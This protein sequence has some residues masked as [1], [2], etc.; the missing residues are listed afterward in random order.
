MMAA[1]IS[2][3]RKP[4]KTTTRK[5]ASTVH[6]GS[7][8]PAVRRAR[9]AVP[10]ATMLDVSAARTALFTWL[11]ARRSGGQLVI[12]FDDA[13]TNEG[14]VL[15]DLHWLGL[16]WDEPP[17]HRA[18]REALY[19]THLDR[20]IAAKGVIERD[21]VLAFPLAPGTTTVPDA[22]KGDVAFDHRAL[23]EVVVAS[24]AG[25]PSHAF[26]SAV[27]DATM[28]IDLVVEDDDQLEA[29]AR[30]TLL[31]QALGFAPPR[32]AHVGPLVDADHHRLSKRDEAPTIDG[33]RR[34]G[35]Q[36]SA[37]VQHLALLG[38]S[39]PDGGES[40]TI[41][42]LVRS[43][44]LERVGGAPSVF[45]L[46]RLRAFNGRAL[47]A[48]SRPAYHDLLAERMQRARL[49]E[50]PIP[51]A[52]HRWIET[53]LDA[54]GDEVHTLGEAIDIIAALREESV[55]VPALEL[56]RLRNR[57][58]LFF[59]DSVSQY[60]DAQP[61]LR[62]LPLEHDLPA[63]ADEFG[64]ARQDAFPAVRM[65]LSGTHDGPPLRLLFPLLGHDR[66]MMR[67]GAVS[68][69][70]LHGRGLEPIRFGPGGVP[71]ETIRPQATGEGGDGS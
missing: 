63:I 15:Y 24:A 9:F 57:H 48:L 31:A 32:F 2:N 43:F 58:V 49:L 8:N 47:R 50:D 29:A 7:Q 62:G 53:F 36:P 52:A 20:L 68:S 26:A 6:S 1:V 54:Y 71:F 11:L 16:E 40:F 65:A 21:G 17:V 56:E 39:P 61:E 12:R 23:G 59:L 22:V 35:F 3:P 34:A 45:D 13:A 69:H 38:W 28:E 30:Q 14:A 67:I 19:R 60:V 70:I 4:K 25:H 10:S 55:I 18:A 51:E 46:G 33:L 66:I 42:E 27:D 37:I 64:I 41:D 44:S 5:T